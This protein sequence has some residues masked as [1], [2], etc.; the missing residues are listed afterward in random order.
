LGERGR[1]CKLGRKKRG[2]VEICG[3]NAGLREKEVRAI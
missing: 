2:T 1:K 3:G